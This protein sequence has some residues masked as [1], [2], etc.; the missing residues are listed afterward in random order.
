MSKQRIN[1][2]KKE[3]KIEKNKDSEKAKVLKTAKLNSEPKK[4]IE[5][6]IR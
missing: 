4:Y 6:Y 5:V 3:I 1:V 2:M